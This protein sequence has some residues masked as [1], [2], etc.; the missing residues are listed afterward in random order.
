MSFLFVI[1]GIKDKEC[2]HQRYRLKWYIDE[3][4]SFLYI[5][6]MNTRE[7]EALR[8]VRLKK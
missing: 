6:T 1:M 4:D 7:K 2:F 5:R 3:D 8:A